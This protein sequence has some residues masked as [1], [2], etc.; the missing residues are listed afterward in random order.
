MGVITTSF[1]TASLLSL[2]NY[3]WGGK[4]K[5][6][7]TDFGNSCGKSVHNHLKT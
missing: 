7:R 1:A 2:L 4:D 6:T 3:F 5:K